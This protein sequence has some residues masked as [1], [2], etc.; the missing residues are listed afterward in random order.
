M[1]LNAIEE[2]IRRT[3]A[4]PDTVKRAASLSDHLDRTMG[5]EIRR[6]Q[7]IVNPLGDALAQIEHPLG[8]ALSKMRVALDKL[9][10][11]IP[12]P[13]RL[14]PMGAMLPRPVTLPPLRDNDF[15][16]I[17][18]AVAASVPNFGGYTDLFR[19]VT[20]FQEWSGALA[21]A[22]VLESQEALLRQFGMLDLDLKS[23]ID[24]EAPALAGASQDGAT[25]E[26]LDARMDKLEAMV[27][28]SNELLAQI[29]RKPDRSG[30]YFVLG[31]L[32]TVLSIIAVEMYHADEDAARTAALQRT[33]A[34]VIAMLAGQQQAQAQLEKLQQMQVQLL[35]SVT[36]LEPHLYTHRVIRTTTLRL[37]PGGR[38][39]GVV[40]TGQVFHVLD[41]QGRWVRIQFSCPERAAPRDGWILKKHAEAIPL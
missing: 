14:A 3:N 13:V 12:S 11:R 19:A 8:A 5:H 38:A 6:L 39:D 2:A 20:D 28:Q 16:R 9:P 31:L 32:F 34:N 36:A 37:M 41:K 21:A 29:A 40:D 22:G 17:G 24:E 18:A 7:R 25:P 35:A 26:S 23:A 30:L 15:V 1:E 4:I 33:D 10:S 27:Q